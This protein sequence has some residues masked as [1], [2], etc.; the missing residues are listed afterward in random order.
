MFDLVVMTFALELD[1]PTP[2]SHNP[3]TRKGGAVTQYFDV[4]SAIGK[5]T[6]FP[7][8]RPVSLR[9]PRRAERVVLGQALPVQASRTYLF[10]VVA[11]PVDMNYWKARAQFEW[12][13]VDNRPISTVEAGDLYTPSMQPFERTP[14]PPIRKTLYAQAESPAN[15]ASVR[16]IISVEGISPSHNEAP[17]EDADTGR[18]LVDEVS[19]I[20]TLRLDLKLQE[21][22]NLVYERSPFIVR[23]RLT[24]IPP[25][26]TDA[27]IRLE[28][29]NIT[30]EILDRRVISVPSAGVATDVDF[31][32]LPRG[33]Y[34]VAW[35]LEDADDHARSGWFSAGVV[36]DPTESV[37]TEGSPVALD[38]GFGWFYGRR[39]SQIVRLGAEVL[40]RSG[41]RHVRE[42]LAPQEVSTAPDAL[43]LGHY[44]EALEAQ[45]AAGADILEVMHSWPD[46]VRGQTGS[47]K[48]P[49]VDLSSAYR[50]YHRLAIEA[51][52]LVQ[53]WEPWN[54]ADIF[55]FEGRPEEFAGIQKTAYVALRTANESLTV[56]SCSTC[57]GNQSS[58]GSTQWLSDLLDNGIGRYFDVYNTH[59]YGSPDG[60]ADRL[61]LEM[62]NNRAMGLTQPVWVT[63]TGIGCYQDPHGSWQPAEQAQAVYTVRVLLEALRVG[64]ERL[65]IFFMPEFLERYRDLWGLCRHDLTPK[66]GLIALSNTVHMLGTGR[67]LGTLPLPVDGAHG[68]VYDTGT[69]RVLAAWA[70][71][72]H[73][74]Q[75]PGNHVSAC[76]LYGSPTDPHALQPRPCFYFGVDLPDSSLRDQPTP[77]DSHR[78][79]ALEPLSFVTMLTAAIK[80]DYSYQDP[81]R[82]EPARIREG[83][84]LTLQFTTANFS[85]V[86]VAASCEWEMPE[87]WQVLDQPP[88]HLSAEPWE[89]RRADVRVVPRGV[90]PEDA[91]VRVR[92]RADGRTIPDVVVRLRPDPSFGAEEHSDG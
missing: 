39:G 21:S 88:I 40:K 33:Y 45:H 36:P 12:L 47:I 71:E 74:V 72:D 27:S 6:G 44:R 14:A 57:H 77:R 9:Y 7:I 13:D 1:G 78:R 67:F 5:D 70:K 73:P 64:A 22:G 29:H 92:C 15:A 19:L 61:R 69:S 53:F 4:S 54:E 68:Y 10:R 38:A 58:L 24:D 25:E 60:L 43:D 3:R 37:A 32:E 17:P 48:G 85:N 89:E 84:E 23:T 42:R 75:L 20:Q 18:V 16:S 76:D 51:G 56:T 87:Q 66:P 62:D 83:Q 31:G 46:W 90:E 35:Y 2:A 26:V 28:L 34:Q 49:P 55:F 59:Y 30:G 41:V 86:P 50:L 52:G 63:E 79:S 82:K 80:N 8:D 91:L 81:R 11:Q 65:Y